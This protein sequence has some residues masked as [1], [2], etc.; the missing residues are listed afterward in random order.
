M[1]LWQTDDLHMKLRQDV[2][3]VCEKF[4]RILFIGAQIYIPLHFRQFLHNGIADP[5]F[6]ITQPKTQCLSILFHF[7]NGNDNID[8]RTRCGNP[9]TQVF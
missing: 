9:H 8:I 2:I 3:Y 4:F 5:V 7:F 6:G 1:I